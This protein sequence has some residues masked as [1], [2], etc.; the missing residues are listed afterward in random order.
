MPC[1]ASPATSAKTPPAVHSRCRS[2][3]PAPAFPRMSPDFSPA[4]ASQPAHSPTPAPASDPPHT[5]TQTAVPPGTGS[6]YAPA[7][8]STGAFSPPATHRPRRPPSPEPAAPPARPAA[9]PTFHSPALASAADCCGTSLRNSA[10]R[11]S[12]SGDPA[13]RPA[14]AVRVGPRR[15]QFDRPGTADFDSLSYFPKTKRA[16]LPQSTPSAL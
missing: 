16:I 10:H 1:K 11:S 12:A 6:Y 2:T 8:S 4:P 7:E 15:P 9:S 13:P 14:S 5:E 3:Y